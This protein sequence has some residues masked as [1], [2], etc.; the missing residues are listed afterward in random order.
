MPTEE[1]E[2]AAAAQSGSCLASKRTKRNVSGKNHRAQVCFENKCKKTFVSTQQLTF[3]QFYVI[4]LSF[5]KI[6]EHEH[7]TFSNA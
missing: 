4:N 1:I 2:L 6:H 3:E 7:Q 5:W